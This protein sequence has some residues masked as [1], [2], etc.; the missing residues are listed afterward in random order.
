MKISK[1]ILAAAVLLVA[2]GGCL[3]ARRTWEKVS[4][5]YLAKWQYTDIVYSGMDSERLWEGIHDGINVGLRDW[6]IEEED[7]SHLDSEWVRF[8]SARKRLELRVDDTK[9]S[10]GNPG[11]L[12]SL[13]VLVQKTR[14]VYTPNRTE[15]SWKPAGQDE[16]LE[17]LIL[18]RI[19]DNLREY[20]QD[21]EE[22][23]DTEQ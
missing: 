20:R 10:D 8:G 3:G 19:R 12:V 2:F 5:F 18:A 1:A 6:P 11:Y 9:D 16:N 21:D 17:L 4:P 14:E 15:Y 23:E 22:M 7:D 13:R